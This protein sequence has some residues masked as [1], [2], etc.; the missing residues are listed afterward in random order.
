MKQEPV[1]NS[2]KNRYNITWP[3]R[4]TP[5]WTQPYDPS[6][7]VNVFHVREP[8]GRWRNGYLRTNRRDC[9]VGDA[10]HQNEFCEHL[11]SMDAQEVGISVPLDG[12]RIEWWTFK[13][14]DMLVVSEVGDRMERFYER[15]Q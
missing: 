2:A 3:I 11:I 15:V 10:V 6:L 4:F 8:I 12:I 14:V 1:H 7:G 13:A 9:Q 5:T